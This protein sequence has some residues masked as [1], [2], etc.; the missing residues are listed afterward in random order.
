MTT[1]I[2]H[3]TSSATAGNHREVRGVFGSV[4]HP[5]VG[6]R[7]AAGSHDTSLPPKAP[8]RGAL[9]PPQEC[10][11]LRFDAF[12]LDEANARLMRDGRPLSV[13]PTPFA[14][15]CALAR[16][17]GSLVTKGAL[18]DAVWGHRFVSEAVLKTAISDLRTLLEDDARS[19]RYIET[20][21][22]RGYRF[23]GVASAAMAKVATR[24]SERAPVPATPVVVGRSH[25]L[26]R[27]RA[28]W[29]AACAGQRTFVWVAG[30]PG[31]G[32]TTL[33]DAFVA[34]LGDVASARGQCVEQYGAGEP[35]LPI[36]E[37]LADLSRRDGSV[38]QLLRSVAP[39]WLLQLPWLGTPEQRTALR[40]E[41]AG[42]PGDRML[43]EMGE[44]LDRYTAQR[45][46]LLVTEDLHWSD[47]ATLQ[48]IDHVA[49]R[50]GNGRLLWLVSFRL[51]DVVGFNRPL[52]AL[53]HELRLHGLCEE[54]VLDPFSEQDVADYVAQRAPSLAADEAFVR[55]LY[56][57]TDGLPPY[58][59]HVLNDLLAHGASGA[60]TR[61]L[62][63]M[64]VPESLAGIIEH[65][66]AQ[67]SSDERTVLETAAVCGVDFRAGTIAT[68]LDRDAAS[69]AT[70]CGQLARGRLWLRAHSD[71]ESDV[72][73]MG[74]SFRHVVFR[75]C[76]YE[77]IG[78]T[79]RTELE[80]KVSA[81]LERQ[82]TTGAAAAAAKTPCTSM[83]TASA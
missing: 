18:L 32:K 17:P 10:V 70:L 25:E 43:R 51:V 64:R 11:R 53:R 26:A 72:R 19:P 6:S 82:C 63:R 44:L 35:Y 23:I 21:S 40:G 30:D 3:R 77:R 33:I 83:S 27:L 81:V 36:L 15:L 22:R 2:D 24:A 8:S 61:E 28:A 13:A 59:A 66:V 34:S 68:V 47:G 75:Q 76:L 74:Y 65:Y 80:C 56:E 7:R 1:E 4:G 73:E 46:L 5:A 45:P 37:A 58:V 48:L 16:Q 12:E 9:P 62:S 39:A 78:R 69:V 57:R 42:S 79:Q 60:A 20:V 29:D 41:L 67:L 55:E 54:L 31:I 14:V 50:R 49:R 38:L 71:D 52:N